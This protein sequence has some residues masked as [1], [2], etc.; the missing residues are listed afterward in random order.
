MNQ[1]FKQVLGKDLEL[2]APDQVLL[3]FTLA[4]LLLDR[5]FHVPLNHPLPVVI[6]TKG[7]RGRI[8][9]SKMELSKAGYRYLAD[10]TER[11]LIKQAQIKNQLLINHQMISPKKFKQWIIQELGVWLEIR[12]IRIVSE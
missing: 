6:S 5:L 8:I 10:L 2:V 7:R 4:I 12:E 1:I 11:Y 3:Y 9:R